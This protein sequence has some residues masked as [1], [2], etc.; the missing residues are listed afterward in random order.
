VPEINPAEDIESP[1]GN[2]PE[3]KVVSYVIKLPE[4]EEAES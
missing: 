4:S 2:V 3:T 1:G